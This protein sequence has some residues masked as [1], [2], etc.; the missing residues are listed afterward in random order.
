MTL[1]ERITRL[2]SELRHLADVSPETFAAAMSPQFT[3]KLLAVVDA[4]LSL[5]GMIESFGWRH[6]VVSISDHGSTHVDLLAGLERA[7]SDLEVAG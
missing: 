4:T 3:L 6:A 7:L 1:T 5:K 2:T